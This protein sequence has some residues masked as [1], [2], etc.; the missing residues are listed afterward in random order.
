MT[1]S[2]L[3]GRHSQKW[4][5]DEKSDIEQKQTVKNVKRKTEQ[6]IYI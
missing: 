4:M 3:K 1:K 6:K 5:I 2:F